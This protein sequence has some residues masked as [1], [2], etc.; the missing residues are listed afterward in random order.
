MFVATVARHF[1]YFHEPVFRML[2]QA[3]WQVDACAKLESEG[4]RPRFCDA[5]FDLPFARNP[6][7][8]QNAKAFAQL[9]K[10]MREARYDIIH[11]HT[12]V[13]GL[14]G[15]LAAGHA[16]VI[17]T[18][19][20]FHFFGGAPARNWLMY[21]PIEKMLARKTDILITINEE[22]FAFARR[23]LP[24]KK[25][26]QVH[27]VGCDAAR[28]APAADATEKMILRTRLG[29]PYDAPVLLYAAEL[30]KNKNQALLLEAMPRIREEFP[31]ALLLLVG[32]DG[33]AQ[34]NL[35]QKIAPPA[36]PKAK[37]GRRT[38]ERPCYAS[39]VRVLGERGDMPALLAAA[40]VY[41]ASSLREGLPANVMEAMAAA[42][43]VVALDNRGHRAL[44]T[45]DTGFLVQ[46]ARQMAEQVCL[47][48]RDK[49]L[50]GTL[51]NAGRARVA[52]HFAQA[53]VL[54]ELRAVYFD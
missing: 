47:L 37:R 24:A 1:R 42:L 30:S 34:S 4:R 43:P 14:L 5:F 54:E 41:V 19:H 18:A 20:G 25:I 27:G 6:F 9:K 26:V 36:V 35:E 28:F 39:Q 52:R 49:P 2:R 21:Y 13:G 23:K 51:G 29:I 10:I 3:G 15:R 17:Y 45:E 50:R 44:V 48:L 31:Q 16:R 32:P 12:P 46:N 8:P 38:A 53:R 40:D 7:A 11:C 22:D 33:G